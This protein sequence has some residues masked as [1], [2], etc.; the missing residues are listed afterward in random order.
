MTSELANRQ[1]SKVAALLSVSVGDGNRT[2]ASAWDAAREGRGVRGA[3]L[4]LQSLAR[5][6]TLKRECQQ[7]MTQSVG[8]CSDSKVVPGLSVGW[9]PSR[10]EGD[11]SGQVERRCRATRLVSEGRR[12]GAGD[13]NRTRVFSLGS[14]PRGDRNWA[15]WPPFAL[16]RGLRESSVPGSICPLLTPVFLRSRHAVGTKSVWRSRCLPGS[17]ERTSD[18]SRRMR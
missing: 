18:S 4:R 15:R 5:C 7:A 16:V 6:E 12:C 9:P 11:D 1:A 10:F 14:F 17:L 2:C 8:C 3:P 13:E